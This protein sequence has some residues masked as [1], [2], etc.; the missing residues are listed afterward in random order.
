MAIPDHH[1]RDSA[2]KEIARPHVLAEVMAALRM[3]L[4]AGDGFPVTSLFGCQR[5]AEGR[6]KISL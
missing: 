3:S 6:L 1:K 4:A 2:P 5:S